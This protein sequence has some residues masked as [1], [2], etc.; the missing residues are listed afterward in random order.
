M[1]LHKNPEKA[2]WLVTRT[3][4]QRKNTEAASV[5]IL[6]GR[7]VVEWGGDAVIPEGVGG[8]GVRTGL[9]ESLGAC[10]VDEVEEAVGRRPLRRVGPPHRDEPSARRV[11]ASA[12]VRIGRNDGV[13]QWWGTKERL[14]DPV[15][16]WFHKRGGQCL[17]TCHRPSHLFDAERGA[18]RRRGSGSGRTAR[19]TRSRE[20]PPPPGYPTT[21]TERASWVRVMVGV[22]PNPPRRPSRVPTQNRFR[23]PNLCFVACCKVI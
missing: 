19:C 17:K 21:N 10:E 2:R 5:R 9:A 13:K 14:T 12:L 16:T 22:N 15:A 8:G 6:D 23:L 3:D 11:L 4:F 20:G 7:S 1:H 18:G